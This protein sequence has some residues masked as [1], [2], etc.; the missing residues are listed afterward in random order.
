MVTAVVVGPERKVAL[1]IK[2][3]YNLN[4]E[5]WRYYNVIFI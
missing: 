1:V 2:I 5:E 4:R 3:K